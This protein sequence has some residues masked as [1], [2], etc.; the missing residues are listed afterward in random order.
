MAYGEN[1]RGG[2]MKRSVRIYL[3][4]EDCGSCGRRV[5]IKINIWMRNGKHDMPSTQ[6]RGMQ[7]K[8]TFAS[9]KD[10]KENIFRV[11]KQMSTENQGVIGEKCIRGDDGNLSFGDTSKMLA[12]KQNYDRLLNIEIL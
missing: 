12:W 6:L 1:K 9:V 8:R 11:A 10:N 4:R 2:G 5:G 7:K 3:R